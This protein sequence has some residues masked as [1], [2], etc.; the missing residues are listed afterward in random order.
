MS[1]ETFLRLPEE[2]R[3]RV[4]EAAWEEFTRVRHADV[5]INK[6]ILKARIPRGSFYQYFRDKDDLFSCLV[7]EIQNDLSDLFLKILREC[8]G[9]MFRLF[10]AAYDRFTAEVPQSNLSLSRYIRLANLNAG[11]DMEKIL[12]HG[13]DLAFMRNAGELLD[14]SAFRR[15]DPEDV[16]LV[17]S[18]MVVA[19][20]M[21]LVE[22]LNHPEERENQRR[23]LERRLEIL[24]YGC[25][26]EHDKEEL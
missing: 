21:A 8:E 2:K 11:M 15:K 20:G 5:S 17:F 18:M 22:C 14:L 6:I 24:R 25:L 19:F 13:K 7:E 23:E 16:Q 12:P 4:M 1:T 26:L 9:D 10:P 3:N